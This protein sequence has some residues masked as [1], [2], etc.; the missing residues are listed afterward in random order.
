[1]TATATL[2]EQVLILRYQASDET[3]LEQIVERYEGRLRY[4]VRRLFGDV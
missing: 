1:M 3:A 4:F 2:L